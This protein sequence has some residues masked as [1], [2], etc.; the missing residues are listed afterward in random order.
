MPHRLLALAGLAF[1]AALPAFAHEDVIDGPSGVVH[2]EDYIQGQGWNKS[3]DRTYAFWAQYD[4]NLTD[5]LTMPQ[6]QR[7]ITVHDAIRFAKRTWDVNILDETCD[8][9]VGQLKFSMG[10][11][12]VEK[13]M[14]LP[15]FLESLASTVQTIQECYLEQ[16]GHGAYHSG[17]R[18]YNKGTVHL[19]KARPLQPDYD[20]PAHPDKVAIKALEAEV[21]AEDVR[22]QPATPAPATKPEDTKK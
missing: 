1:A 14:A 18:N 4:D 15:M 12:A 17:Y 21:Q 11:G 20:H 16:D 3:Q 10:F 6:C 2:T 13:E 9:R 19:R 22:I 7:W 8:P 5:V